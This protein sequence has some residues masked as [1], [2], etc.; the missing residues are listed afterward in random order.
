MD[1]S[2]QFIAVDREW[3]P[4]VPAAHAEAG[5]ALQPDSRSACNGG[6]LML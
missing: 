1:H 4:G 3:V 6:T 2:E 5:Y